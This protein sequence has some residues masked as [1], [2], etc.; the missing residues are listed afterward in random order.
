[1]DKLRELECFVSVV[2]AG[3]FVRA[4]DRIGISTTAISRAVLGLEARLH[5]R[6][7][8]RTTR[9]LA[10]TEIGQ[11]YFERC[12]LILAAVQEADD[13][14]SEAGVGT[15]GRLRVGAPQ[16]FGVLCLARLW[17]AFARQHPDVQLDVVLSDGLSDLVGEH[18]DVAI[19]IADLTQDGL[20]HR[21]L[22]GTRLIA[23]AAPSYLARCGV[24]QHPCALAHHHVVTYSY[25]AGKDDWRFQG[26]DGSHVVRVQPRMRANNG[27]TCVAA[28]RDGLGIILQP[29]FLVDDAIRQ[30]LLVPLLPN[31]HTHTLGVYAV[32]PSHR[33]VPAKVRVLVDF[34]CASFAAAAGV[35]SAQDEGAF[36]RLEIQT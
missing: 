32:Y 35:R 23:C 14:L 25:F 15:G 8:H 4:A 27:D 36:N 30:G 2:E 6:L 9:R 33:H 5:A 3:S 18:L 34:L 26:A 24:P 16:S 12:K 19:R 29:D 10:L 17:P 22:A 13:L 31:Y 11:R 7:L 21:R 28:A 1:M 20:V